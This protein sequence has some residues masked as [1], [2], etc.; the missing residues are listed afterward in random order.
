MYVETH[1]TRAYMYI[2]PTSRKKRKATHTNKISYE[3][4]RT[5]VKF[6]ISIP[7]ECVVHSNTKKCLYIL[8]LTLCILR[9]SQCLLIQICRLAFHLSFFH[10]H[11][12]AHKT[13]CP[14]LCGGVSFQKLL[15]G[16]GSRCRGAPWG[17]KRYSE[18]RSRNVIQWGQ[19]GRCELSPR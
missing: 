18:N 12:Q 16:S 3:N 15:P 1:N 9:H 17:P 4:A 6:S 19:S 14:K 13:K 10:L 11:V 7:H 8:S 2:V 5:Y